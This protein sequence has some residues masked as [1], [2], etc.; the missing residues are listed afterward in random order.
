MAR[1]PIF[2]YDGP[3]LDEQQMTTADPGGYDAGLPAVP[4]PGADGQPQMIESPDW[5]ADWYRNTTAGAAALPQNNLNKERSGPT[6]DLGGYNAQ[7]GTALPGWDQ[8]K[9][10]DPNMRNLKYD[11]GR[12]I[13]ASGLAPSDQNA[14]TIIQQ[15]IDGGYNIKTDPNDPTGFWWDNT[16][17]GPWGP[18][19]TD[20]FIRILGG[21]G[22][23]MFEGAPHGDAGTIDGGLNQIQSTIDNIM[24][25]AN[26]GST[27][28]GGYSGGGGAGGGVP[29]PQTGSGSGG[30][31]INGI[32]Q[33]ILTGDMNQDV[34][35]KRL[36][37]A[38]DTMERTRTSEMD[39]LGAILADRGL[40]G[41]GSEIEG[42]SNLSDQLYDTY[43][44]TTRDIYADEA[45]RADDRFIQSLSLATGL[46]IEDAKRA[47]D[48]YN[49]ET[50]RD[51]GMGRLSLDAQL[52][53]RELDLNEMLGL[54]NL[55]IAR[56][57][58]GLD[59]SL[60]FGRLGLDELGLN[61]QNN[62]FLADYGLRRDQYLNDSGNTDDILSII[63]AMLSAGGITAG[64]RR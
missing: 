48:W 11:F 20:E 63:Q 5:N 24:A 42:L 47:V 32:L 31:D 17:A 34:L 35:S 58:L 52:G 27:G 46:S 18:A 16:E 41:S 62:Q 38:R 4:Q 39:S 1:R 56:G 14:A 64:G 43:A 50:S 36:E 61:L 59:S 60:G 8:T 10:S 3:E 29:A 22:N 53:N 15:M 40:I 54:G 37:S 6:G 2:G 44:S 19:G 33:S 30:L 12:A 25:A 21:G 49:A 23:W 26:G 7:Y 55:D 28:G 9:W 13:A 45:S 57:R 51:V